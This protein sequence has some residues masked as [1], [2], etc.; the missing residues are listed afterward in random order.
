MLDKA[1]AEP[2]VILSLVGSLV[3]LVVAFGCDLSSAQQGAVM[4]VTSAFLGLLI[5]SQVTPAQ[6]GP[7]GE[8]RA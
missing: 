4:A 7:P 8:H 2:A 1:R 3:A 5:R 6:S